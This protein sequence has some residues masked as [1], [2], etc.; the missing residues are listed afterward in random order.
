MFA[1]DWTQ[2]L[3]IK[4][5]KALVSNERSFILFYLF[6]LPSDNTESG[7]SLCLV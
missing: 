1:V 5:S 3:S 7:N 4:P 6:I 2:S